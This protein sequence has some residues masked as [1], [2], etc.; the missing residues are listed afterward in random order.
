MLFF[1]FFA[2]W[3]EVLSLLIL[4]RCSA[5]HTDTRCCRPEERAQCSLA[6]GRRT[7]STRLIGRRREGGCVHAAWPVS[8]SPS[9]PRTAAVAR[10]AEVRPA[11]LQRVALR[12]A[13]SGL[14]WSSQPPRD[15]PYPRF[16]DRIRWRWPARRRPGNGVTSRKPLRGCWRVR[17]AQGR[18]MGPRFVYVLRDRG[19]W[20][21]TAPSH[22]HGGLSGRGSVASWQCQ[23][24]RTVLVRMAIIVGCRAYT[25]YIY[26]HP[27]VFVL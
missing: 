21:L 14:L 20:R 6:Q 25:V 5:P 23:L 16:N 8:D 2:R 27:D 17:S 26:C 3:C 15:G 12:A 18:P 1:F 22:A 10:R 7:M 24:V 9:C 13:G 4:L 11:R 19:T